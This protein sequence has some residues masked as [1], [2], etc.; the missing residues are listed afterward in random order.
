MLYHFFILSSL[1]QHISLCDT[2]WHNVWHSVTQCLTQRNTM[3]DTVWHNVWHS[4][5]QYLTQRNTMSNTNH[6]KSDT[7]RNVW[8]NVSSNLAQQNYVTQWHCD[9]L[10]HHFC[11]PLC[12]KETFLSY[13]EP[14][15]M[16]C[17]AAC[18]STARVQPC[19][20]L[21]LCNSQVKQQG[22]KISSFRRIFFTQLREY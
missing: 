10:A 20:L 15:T 7:R 17:C 14:S 16:A 5:T 2:T 8:H 4:V 1:A 22:R 13:E 11:L 12:R 19:I 21:W 6:T 9:S 3:S 18:Q